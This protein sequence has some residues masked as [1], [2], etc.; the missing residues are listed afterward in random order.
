MP[1]IV[2]ETAVDR[3]TFDG[4]TG[5]LTSL[6]PKAL[7]ELELIATVPDCPT[8][9]LQ[10]LT[11]AGEYRCADSHG[12]SQTDIACEETD[13]GQ[14]LSLCYRGLCAMDV[15]VVITIRTALADAFARWSCTVRNG[16][17]I[18][19]TD[20]QFPVLIVPEEGT[21]L[22]AVG[23]R[24]H[25]TSGKALQALPAD[26]PAVWEFRVE[27]KGGST[28]YPGHDFAQFLAWYN[29]D[30]AGTP[31]A[32]RGVYAACEDV[33]GNIKRFHA[34]RREPGIRLG[35]AHI[36]DW[37]APGERTL[38]YD[39][40]VRSF[41]GDWYDAADIYRNWTLAQKWA[42]T[43]TERTDVPESLLDS[44]P[45]ITIR[46]Q[47][48]VDEGPARPIEEFLP[49]EKS[50][51]LLEEIA[52][53]V[54]SSL[55]PI[56]M[57]WERA[58]PWIYPDCFPPIAGDEALARFIG[59]ANE[60]G[61]RV[62]LLA[63]GTRWVTEH[64]AMDYDGRK[65]FEERD[66]ADSVCRLPDGEMW[67]T[68]WDTDWR[69]SYLGCAAQA[70][71]KDIA[72]DAMKRIV[73]WGM[74]SIQFFD[75]N[76]GCATFPCFASDHGHPPMPGKWMATAMEEMVEAFGRVAEEAGA[77]D[78]YQSVECACN[79]FCLPL[80]PQCDERIS[81]PSS[82]RDGY[83]PLYHY[84][85]HEC[86][87]I[88]GMMSTGSEPFKVPI[89]TAWNCVW[90]EIPG[91]VITGDGT[92]LNRETFNWAEWEPKIGSNDD[93]LEMIRTVTA[94]R[95]GPGRDFLLY[96]RMQRP[97]EVNAEVMSWEHN[98]RTHEVPAVADAAWQAPDGR[99]AIILANW[100]TETQAAAIADSRL[101]D[102]VTVNVCGP[103]QEQATHSVTDGKLTVSVPRLSCALVEKP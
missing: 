10:Y 71:T 37:P 18:R 93:A 72:T 29:D 90:G 64:F 80:F 33:E 19:L 35:I 96:G 84:L 46:V 53:R 103:E 73:G 92:L 75:Q 77:A 86:I 69:P 14:A 39:V 24:N 38:E 23:D 16:A 6:R 83:I 32:G 49:Y 68:D 36:G 98:D 7:P 74:E 22:Q 20:V 45:H 55:V 31:A 97:G 43:L 91:A 66:G 62:G 67:S 42:T 40:V 15:D 27:N 85:F 101:G 26:E 102:R 28:H 25:L 3:L 88:N 4:D 34:L 48:Y 52:C 94:M 81:P 61:W 87:I 1:H 8:F 99:F 41:E 95:R 70:M 78:A 47:G 89:S 51:P 60:R 65:D 9:V 30:A 76:F 13:A 57:S 21:V 54:E 11:D 56:V 82:G 44:P 5:R 59:M 63:N 58:G 50:I 17:G 100:T 2:L 12:A 79:E